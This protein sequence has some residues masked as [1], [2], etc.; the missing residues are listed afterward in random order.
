MKRLGP[1]ALR[2]FGLIVLA[3]VALGLAPAQSCSGPG[4]CHA[5]DPA[6]DHDGKN[7]DGGSCPALR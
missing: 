4:V 7:P 6:T 5:R 2:V 3:S 1:R